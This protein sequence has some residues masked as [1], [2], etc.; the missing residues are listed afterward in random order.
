MLK[1]P[2]LL[3]WLEK[4]RFYFKCKQTNNP[5]STYKLFPV[6]RTLLGF[7]SMCCC[8]QGDKLCASGVRLKIPPKYFIIWWY[9]ALTRS[10][11][12]GGE[13]DSEEFSPSTPVSLAFYCV[14]EPLGEL[15][16]LFFLAITPRN[17]NAGGLLYR[18]GDSN[19]VNSQIALA[20][21]SSINNAALCRRN[22][23][24][25]Q[26]KGKVRHG[27]AKQLASV[28]FTS[29]CPNRIFRLQEVLAKAT[30]WEKEHISGRENSLA[31]IQIC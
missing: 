10:D 7:Q 18:P 15:M 16:K 11:R 8:C 5:G 31:N 19:A 29:L 17:S 28:P 6:W 27:K 13:R 22:Y 20:K 3:K 30:Y 23:K 25:T 12:Y 24:H 9:W 4:K 26:Q 14:S 1:I 2:V 21:I